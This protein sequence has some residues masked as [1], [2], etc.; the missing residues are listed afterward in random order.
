MKQIGV[1]TMEGYDL[2]MNAEYQ[3][4]KKNVDS[5]MKD[6]ANRMKATVSMETAKVS[7]NLSGNVSNTSTK[8]NDS[9][10]GILGT[11]EAIKN[12]IDSIDP[13]LNIDGKEFAI[14]ITPHVS[15]EL[16]RRRR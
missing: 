12:S 8:S 9:D 5:N 10:S 3:Q 14:A 13:S 2:G 11:L 16:V 6:I 15:R 7:A 4:V 1:Y